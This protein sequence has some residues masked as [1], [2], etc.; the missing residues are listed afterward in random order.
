MGPGYGLVGLVVTQTQVTLS[1]GV[2]NRVGSL[3]MCLGAPQLTKYG[4][5]ATTASVDLNFGLLET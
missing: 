4:V 2:S 3:Y 5:K 1:V